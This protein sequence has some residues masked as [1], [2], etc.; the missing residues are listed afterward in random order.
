MV[1]IIFTTNKLMVTLISVTEK[2]FYS[3][4]FLVTRKNTIIMID[5][6]RTVLNLALIVV[7]VPVSLLYPICGYDKT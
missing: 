4:H 5:S 6:S 2:F 7:N 3:V 1:R